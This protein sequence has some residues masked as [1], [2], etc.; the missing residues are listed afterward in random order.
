MFRLLKK[1]TSRL[2]R[3]FG[4]LLPL[5]LAAPAMAQWGAV[6]SQPDTNRFINSQQ[7]F[8]LIM[9]HQQVI[10]GL[11]DTTITSAGTGGG[12]ASKVIV[13][14]LLD[15]EDNCA[16]YSIINGVASC[17]GSYEKWRELEKS[18]SWYQADRGDTTAMFPTNY[19]ITVSTGKDSVVVWNRDTAELW[20]AFNNTVTNNMLRPIAGSTV[21]D[22][23]L[24][25]GILYAGVETANGGLV[26]I[27]FLEASHAT[28][29]Y[30]GTF[31][32]YNGDIHTR[33][34]AQG[35]TTAKNMGIANRNVSAV[36]V[37][38]DPFGLKDA[39]GRP[40]HN[41]AAG[42]A[43]G[44]S[45]YNS[46][47][48]AIY[49]D[50]TT[51]P[52]LSITLSRSGTLRRTYDG[53][54]LDIIGAYLQFGQNNITGISADG[55]SSLL[56]WHSSAAGGAD[57]AWADAA[58]T[59]QN[60]WTEGGSISGQNLAVAT[61]GSSQGVYKLHLGLGDGGGTISDNFAR[62]RWSS[63]VN[64]PVEFGDAVLA[65]GLEDQSGATTFDSSPYANAMTNN[66]SPGTV[67]AVFG[68]G[69][70]STVG[71]DL[72]R[73]ADSDFNFG[74]G[75]MTTMVWFKSASATNPAHSTHLWQFI[76][77][78]QSQ[79]Y[80]VFFGGTTGVM[81][82]RIL[83]GANNTITI[84]IDFLDGNWHHVVQTYDD[85]ANIQSLYVD[86]ILIGTLAKTFTDITDVDD[87]AIGDDWNGSNN[88]EGQL[89]DFVF[90]H[91]YTNAETVAKIHAEGRKK[92][93]MG[94]PVFTRTPD[95]ALISNNVVDI[96]ALDNGM[97][98]VAF[99]DANTVQVFDGRI[100]VQQIAAPAGTV[101]SVALIQSPGADSVGV[102]IGTTTNLKFVQPAVNLRAAMAHQY[103]E[104]IHVGSPVVVDSAGI[105]GIFWTADDAIDAGDNAKR[106]HIY[107]MDGTYGPFDI[108]KDY[109]TVECSSTHKTST[110]L[111]PGVV[112]NGTGDDSIDITALGV[113]VKYC[114]TYSAQSGGTSINGF[115]ITSGGDEYRLMFNIVISSDN[116]GIKSD[117][118]RGYIFGNTVIDADDRGISIESGGG[119]T[120]IL[121]NLGVS[122]DVGFV[123]LN[124]TAE[125]NVVTN[126]MHEGSI[127]DNSGTST[128]ANNETY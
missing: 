54:G 13:G 97:W 73:L 59:T 89:D 63:A 29:M 41:W 79:F 55:W 38:R 65:L 120:R 21:S 56:S 92:L 23:A 82:C 37:A 10:V 126:N 117:A 42:T 121:G 19:A 93:A 47:K 83:N 2:V 125:N 32:N 109:I 60:V 103:K 33:N 35:F 58:G 80:D 22:I 45:V 119:E 12:N 31:D 14:S 102:A 111:G 127:E 40:K 5:V 57:I 48:N 8:G 101:K 99:S 1:L 69:Y 25:D 104:P 90:S 116:H 16:N 106:S 70:S 118:N 50:A 123:L 91:S 95:D 85:D 68:N 96:D 108:D 46:H 34:G 110:L 86:G 112:I 71:S 30:N 128:V 113:T 64:A 84:A 53:A 76:N 87:L 107:I 94:T 114:G 3:V 66:N 7:D 105:G 36:A 44:G 15:Y 9:P 77:G 61:V 20:M 88:F 18:T 24:K 72:S 78:A 115:N 51:D 75:S 81:Y 39:L 11:L 124:T 49:D 4:T 100:P 27:D 74:T 62:Q 6:T 52:T 26:E 28:Y 98:A 67:A 122:N 43:G 17:A